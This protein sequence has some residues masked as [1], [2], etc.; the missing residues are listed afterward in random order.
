[1]REK[2]DAGMARVEESYESLEQRLM[3]LG[4]WSLENQKQLIDG[5]S[6]A[7]EG[8]N[9]LH[10]FQAQALEESRETIQKLAQL[11][12]DSKKSYWPGK[13]KS[14]KPMTISSKTRT[15]HWKH[16]KTSE[17]SRPTILLL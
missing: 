11:G 17:Q 15:P 16:R 10:S 7:T 2:I 14:G 12:S 5:Q 6:R 9:N 1:M 3:I 13:N 8:L 4:V